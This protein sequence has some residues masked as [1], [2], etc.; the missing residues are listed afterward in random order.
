[1]LLKGVP[2]QKYILLAGDVLIILLS[3]LLAFPL[4]TGEFVNFFSVYTGASFLTIILFPSV[5]YI[6]D[7]Y[8]LRQDYKSFKTF[9]KII[10]A[11]MGG[12]MVTSFFFYFFT[13]YRYSRS[14]FFLN[15]I[16][17]TSFVLL[18]RLFYSNYSRDIIKPRHIM[19]MGKDWV[20]ETLYTVLVGNPEYR[21]VGF[22]DGERASLENP[23]LLQLPVYSIEKAKEVIKEEAVEGVV[24]DLTEDKSQEIW[25]SLLMLKMSGVEII[26]A[27]TLYQDITGKIPIQSVDDRWLVHAPGYN[28]LTSGFIQRVKRLYDVGISLALLSIAIPVMGLVALAVRF[29]SPGPIFYRQTRVGKDEKQFQLI[30]FRTMV[31]DAELTTGA[32]WAGE[33]D[34]RITR[35]GKLLRITRMDELPQLLNVL[36]E[37]MSFI[38]PRPE[39]PEFVRGLEEKIPYYLCRHAI[40]PGITGWAQ[41]N[42]PYGA[43][44][45]DAIE[46]LQYDLFYIQNMSILLDIRIFLKTIPVV[47]FGKGSR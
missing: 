37:E 10:A 43:S 44:I 20:L 13:S 47:L 6:A 7:L 25:Q 26:G 19:L 24:T 15:V 2:R 9:I 42:Y 18:W 14:V 21:V 36:R 27:A 8:N 40:R 3:T 38:G 29:D 32:I 41:V 33:N 22:I 28:L 30:K 31:Q 39:R 1:M 12:A 23:T 4:R 45:E 17:L 5:F 11:S 46:K 34:P 35:V 16:T